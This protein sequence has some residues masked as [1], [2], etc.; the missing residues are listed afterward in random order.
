MRK[1]LLTL[2][3]ST[4]LA[5]P[6]T[7]AIAQAPAA[8]P[9]SP[10]T[11]TGNM[12]IASDYRFRGISQTFRGPT[13]QG[14]IDYSH[15]SGLYFG[16]W[17]SN[18]SGNQFVGGPGIEMDFYGGY[19]HSFGDLG[20]DVGLLQYYYGDAKQ[21]GNSLPAGGAATTAMTKY[22][23]TEFYLGGTY[24]WFSAKWFYSLS[25]YFGF[26]ANNANAYVSKDCQK[27]I[28]TTAGGCAA[29]VAAGTLMAANGGSKGSQYVDLGATFEIAPKTSLVG[30]LGWLRVKGY[31]SYFNYTDYKIGVTYDLSGWLLGASLIGT[32]AKSQWYYAQGGSV[33]TVT[34]QR[35]TFKD[36]G[37]S[38]VVLSVTKTF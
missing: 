9:A 26:N 31:G 12:T 15:S 19:K 20:L 14:G 32:N 4:A 17:N 13:I 3:L 21:L 11:V 38:T 22:N 8:A 35:D 25:D 36:T 24:K 28:A 1:S 27:L 6:A 30:H 23:N 18:V 2:A 33:S 37:A 5:V 34:G 7:M 29:T 16:N 10:H